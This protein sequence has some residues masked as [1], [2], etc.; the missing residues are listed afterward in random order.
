MNTKQTVFLLLGLL[1]TVEN[2]F[3]EIP[4]DRNQDGWV[5]FDEFIDYYE[6][7]FEK[8][9]ANKD[10]SLDRTEYKS[11]QFDDAD[12]NQ[13]H[14]VDQI[15]YCNTQAYIFH[16]LDLDEDN[17]LSQE[18]AEK[19]FRLVRDTAG[20][21]FFYKIKHVEPKYR[22]SGFD[23]EKTGYNTVW[24]IGKADDRSGEFAL[25]PD[26]FEEFLEYDF[27]WENR[28]YIVGYS[29]PDVDFPYVL[30]G[31]VNTWGGTWATSGWR[32]HM[33]NILFKLKEEPA[34]AQWKLRV[35]LTGNDSVQATMFKV[36]VNGKSYKEF[37]PT[38]KGS[39]T[40]P[41]NQQ[42]FLM[43]FPIGE[44]QLRDG[45]NE[46]RLSSVR[47][48]WITFDHVSL[49][50]SEMVDIIKPGKA[51]LRHVEPA[52]YEMKANGKRTQPLLVHAGQL[53]STSVL[54]VLL[55]GR[56]IFSAEVEEGEYVFE[57]PM[58][59][60]ESARMSSYEIQLD[61]GTI[62]EGKVLRSPQSLQTAGDYVDTR[63]GTGHSRW[64][65]A[66]G[67]WMPFGMVKLSPDNQNRGWQAGYE[68]SI[69]NIGTFSHIHE[70]TM[71][72]LGIMPSGGELETIMGTE[73]LPDEGYRSR[74]DK[75][76]ETA[77]LG[78][79]EVLLTDY[80]IKAELTSTTRCGFQRY[81][82]SEEEQ[83]RIMIDLK[84][85]AEYPYRIDAA[86]I[87]KI[88]KYR[89]EGSCVQR[90]WA[91]GAMRQDYKVH[92]VVEFD[93]PITKFGV[94]END[95]VYY[96]DTLVCPRANDLGAFAEFN[97]TENKI[98]QVRSSISYVSIEN[99]RENLEKEVIEPFGWDYEAVRNHNREVWNEILGRL[100]ISTQNRIEKIK[101]YTNMYRAIC[102]RNIFSDVNGQWADPSERTK[103]LPGKEDVAL[104]C[105]AFWNTFWNLNQLWNLAAPEWSL[106]WVRSQLAMYK[107]NGW[108]A[109]GPAGM[110][111]VPV[112]VAEHE[113][114]LIVGAYQMGIRDFDVNLA[115][116]A[117]VK[118]QSEIPESY[119]NTKATEELG[120]GRAGNKDLEAYLRHGYVP[121]DKGRFSNSLEYSYDDWTIGQFALAL[122]RDK[123]YKTFNERG[124]WW[125]N[126]MDEETGYARLKDSLGQWK[127]DF[128]PF[129]EGRNKHYVEGN[130]WQLTFFVPQD[131]PA[132]IETIGKDR[133]LER[134][135]WG[136][137]S[138]EPF[139]F[140]APRDQYWD[141][142]VVQGNQQSMHFAYLFNW[143]GKPWLTQKWTRSILNRYYGHCVSNAY[144]G[145]EDQGQMSAWYVMSAIG[146][147]QTDGG[148]RVNP[149]YEIASPLFEKVSIDLG[150]QYG[151]GKTFTIEARNVSR[152]NKYI[153]G[154][155]LNGKP[156]NT[157]FFS[158]SELLKGGSLVLEM[159]AEPNKNW[160]LVSDNSSDN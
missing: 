70:W 66:P 119:F 15:E 153:Q 142:P 20:Q 109:K 78:H 72:G 80:N 52:G 132:L 141:Y 21:R 157:F 50:C 105:D 137:A 120:G 27:G 133:F 22:V 8:A 17:R 84:I 40:H 135:E 83:S 56:Q 51:Y 89:V 125:K 124:Y 61:G 90:A 38:G 92:F 122:G 107:S 160:G 131:V 2:S 116:E 159:G 130:A 42:A 5:L 62:E 127:P 16:Q 33:V 94:W 53:D 60:V 79:Y 152:K 37:I 138:S 149:V 147:F 4:W 77:P 151:R 65:I 101:F 13:N 139:R 59:S 49:L 69:E 7:E 117:V 106:Q 102:G 48:S 114:P 134:L 36:T 85:P 128:D 29:K 87:Q 24:Q 95:K 154:A 91:W 150:R 11:D 118:M 104:G 23:D 144:L 86:E 158:A 55:D 146:L 148:C 58:P 136:F 156:L 45:G 98:V 28:N 19:H 75:D 10:G 31:P 1:L 57:A 73:D 63:M 9:D 143:A 35:A 18:E 115:F 121:Y 14:K 103:Q 12:F 126:V 111:Y 145:D 140:N 113:I 47:G 108:L 44:M 96:L 67:P 34:N 25:A 43:E 81:T 26:R 41:D 39:L 82:Y 112:M 97:T 100:D 74:I 71:G 129:Q 6:K 123:K 3:A 64:M 155:V 99:A 110:E 68:P 32:T 46:I 54:S 88:G 76:T 93:R 30:P